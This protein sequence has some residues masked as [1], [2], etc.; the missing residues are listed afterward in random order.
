LYA[1]AFF[2]SLFVFSLE[3]QHVRGESPALAGLHLSAVPIA[4]GVTSVVAGRLV[5]RF[6]TR[7]PF[8]AGLIT[9]VASAWTAALLPPSAPYAACRP[10]L[11]AMGVGGGLV[12]PTA[13][14]A[15]LASVPPSLSGIGAGVLNVSRQVG[16]AFGVAGFASLFHGANE[17]AAVR[18]SLASAGAAYLVAFA[19]AALAPRPAAQAAPV[20]PRAT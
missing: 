20:R 18:E 16:T 19:A 13:N 3:F 10:A 5:A 11:V 7:G 12:A 2:G 14:A 17:A 15:I 8:L 1:G 9:L 4:F 6:G